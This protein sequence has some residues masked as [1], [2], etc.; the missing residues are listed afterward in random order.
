[1]SLLGVDQQD[2]DRFY[3]LA[4]LQGEEREAVYVS[5]SAGAEGSWERIG[6]VQKMGS[7]VTPPEGGSG[8]EYTLT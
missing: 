3:V 1:M 6:E 7:F 2:P 4:T 5:A 8:P